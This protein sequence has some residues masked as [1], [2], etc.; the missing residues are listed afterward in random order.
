VTAVL[1]AAFAV[2]HAGAAAAQSPASGRDLTTATIEDLMN[3]T[4]T[5]ASRKEQRVEDVPAAVYVIT[6]N[7]IRRWAST[8]A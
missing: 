8:S 7:D 4:I 6:Q 5:S 3:I 1:I 2:A